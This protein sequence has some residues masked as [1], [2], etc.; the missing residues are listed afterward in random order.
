MDTANL[1]LSYNLAIDKFLILKVPTQDPPGQEVA[2]PK[3]SKPAYG[4]RMRSETVWFG[5]SIT[6]STSHTGS[7]WT[8]ICHIFCYRQSPTCY[9]P[10]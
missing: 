2:A 9:Y 3:H 7:E 8:Y 1:Y 4:R 5:F 10:T 6:L